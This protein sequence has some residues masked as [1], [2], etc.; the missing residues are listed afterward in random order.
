MHAYWI[1]IAYSKESLNYPCFNQSLLSSLPN[2]NTLPRLQSHWPW[3]AHQIPLSASGTSTFPNGGLTSIHLWVLRVRVWPPN[4]CTSGPCQI[5][6]GICFMIHLRNMGNPCASVQMSRVCAQL[7]C[8]L[9]SAQ[10][11]NF[12]TSSLKIQ[13][14]NLKSQCLLWLPTALGCSYLA[15]Y[16]LISTSTL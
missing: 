6:Q 1:G 14:K 16:W 8:E 5:V 3:S 12:V 4:I 11:V 15:C 13:C 10:N 9:K 7:K 2:P